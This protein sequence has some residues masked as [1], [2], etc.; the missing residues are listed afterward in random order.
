MDNYYNSFEQKS[1]LL[2]RHT[3]VTG[4][5]YVDMK[6]NP[7]QVTKSNLIKGETIEYSECILLGKW[8]DKRN[9]LYI[10]HNSKTTWS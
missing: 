3:Y 2:T 10:H 8:R 9:V 6:H 7:E 1:K 5:L 4:T